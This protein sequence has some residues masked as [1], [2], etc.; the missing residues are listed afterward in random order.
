MKYR[1]G[2]TPDYIDPMVPDWVWFLGVC[3]VSAAL[4]IW[5]AW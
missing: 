2:W 1:K 5:W 4:A 3:V